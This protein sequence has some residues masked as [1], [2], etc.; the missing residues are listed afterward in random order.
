MVCVCRLFCFA[1]MG[2]VVVEIGLL[3][4]FGDPRETSNVG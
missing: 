4:V 2:F 3:D 1:W